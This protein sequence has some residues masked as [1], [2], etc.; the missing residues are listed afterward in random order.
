M[1]EAVMTEKDSKKDAPKTAAKEEKAA[2]APAPKAAAAPPATAAPKETKKKATATTSASAAAS[3]MARARAAILK[4]TGQKPL[5]PSDTTLGHISTGSLSVD[6]LIG[7]SPAKDGTPVCPGFPKRRITEVY[8]PE[9]SGKTTLLL[10]SIVQ[11]QRKGGAAMFIDFEHALDHNYA[12]KIGVNY[13]DGTFEVYQPDTLE[14]GLKILY[15]GIAAGVDLIGIDSVAAMVPKDELEKN[16]DD[17]ARIGALA[18]KFSNILPKIV[19]WL[20]KFPADKDGKR[21]ADHDGTALVLLNQTRALIG[22]TGHGDNENTSGGKAIK[23]YAYL[24]LRMSRIKSEVVKKKD[25]MTGREVSLPYGN[26]TDVKVVKSKIDA[27]QG[28]RTQLFIRYGYGI[29]DY[30]TV[31]ESGVVNK[32]VKKEGAYF[33]LGEN[34]FQGKDKFRSFLMSNPTIF[35][36]LRKNVL[37]ASMATAV[38][39]APEEELSEED[40]IL[41]GLGDEIDTLEGEAESALTEE[42]VETSDN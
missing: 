17:P 36:T 6:M 25:R 41:E 26:L 5:Q 3:V 27:K 29:D 15:I 12:K 7:G 38:P 19:I 13:D 28:H 34:R 30:F 16:I 8:G 33:A 2:P 4:S 40:A 42:V 39:M 18:A 32:L 14:E 10:S 1:S 11:T 20:T 21:R 24:R 22:G 23:F 37:A 9:S 35:E 31:I